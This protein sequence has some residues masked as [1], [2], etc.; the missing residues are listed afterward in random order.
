MGID[1]GG[2]RFVIDDD[3]PAT[4][5]SNHEY[6]SP[7]EETSAPYVPYD[8][9]DGLEHI[10]EKNGHVI[11]REYME[12][13]ISS[14]AIGCI[15]FREA[16]GNYCTYDNDVVAFSV[17]NII[18]I[19]RWRG[20]DVQEAFMEISLEAAT[21]TE[22]W[23]TL[24]WDEFLNPIA[25]SGSAAQTSFD[26]SLTLFSKTSG[27][28]FDLVST[29]VSVSTPATIIDIGGTDYLRGTIDATHII[30]YLVDNFYVENVEY[31]LVL[32]AGSFASGISSGSDLAA[33]WI[34]EF[35]SERSGNGDPP[36]DEAIRSTRITFGNA[37]LGVTYIRTQQRRTRE[38]PGTPAQQ[39]RLARGQS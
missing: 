27:S 15:P 25:D 21:I 17:S 33:G 26:L 28:T 11:T 7:L 10:S 5:V 9:D 16:S 2:Y 35:Y 24:T 23:D 3:S 18:T 38:R 19:G 6:S 20:A 22:Y 12:P 39:C 14:Y 32:G 34:S 31:L 37:T 13:S 29:G 4:G 36:Y 1:D 8:L 30:K